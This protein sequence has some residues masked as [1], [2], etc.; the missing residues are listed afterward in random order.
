MWRDKAEVDS[1]TTEISANPGGIRV[2]ALTSFT[3]EMQHYPPTNAL[4][5]GFRVYE[6]MGFE[7]RRLGSRYL[8]KTDIQSR[9]TI[10]RGW[11]SKAHTS[12]L[13][14]L[15]ADQPQILSFIS[16][17]SRSHV[18]KVEGGSD[19]GQQLRGQALRLVAQPPPTK[20]SSTPHRWNALS[21][22]TMLVNF[23]REQQ[24]RARLESRPC[25]THCLTACGCGQAPLVLHP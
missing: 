17:V 4:Q 10:N 24:L 2:S 19:S 15:P 23:C 18:K 13:V 11:G 21:A 25:C 1:L 8:L 12:P 14:M 6:Q 22:R 3:R 9:E 20:P 5:P 16:F 7:P